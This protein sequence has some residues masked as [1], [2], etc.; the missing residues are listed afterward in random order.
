MNEPVHFSWRE[1]VNITGGQW[2][3]KPCCAEGGIV[4][5]CDDSRR[6]TPGM[7]FVAIPGELVDG[8]VYVTKA[9]AGGA[10]AVMVSRSPAADELEK[11]TVPCLLVEDSL[12][13]FQEL[14]RAHR[15]RF[16][17]LPLLGITGSCGKTSTKE[18]CAAVL[19]QHFGSQIVK[20]EGNTNNHFGVPRNLFR[21]SPE[22][23]MAVIEMGSNH[24][25]EIAGLA[26]LAEPNVSL[27]CNIGHAHLEF[28]HDLYGVATEKSNI[29]SHCADNGVA[30]FP[31]EAVGREILAKAAGTRRILTFGSSDKA[32]IQSRYLG[33]CGNGEFALELRWKST[34]E[35]RR[36][37]WKLGGLHQAMNA[38][39][40]AAAGTAFG[41]TP[42]EIVAGLINTVLPGKRME[43]V[44]KGGIT[45]ANDAYNAN[46]DSTAAAL[47]W[48]A[49]VCPK[50][51]GQVLVLG[52]MRELGE[53]SAA[54]HEEILSKALEQ[55]PS[56]HI[57][58]VGTMFAASAGKF[59]QANF[60]DVEALRPVL[61]TSLKKGDWVLLKGS[62]GVGLFS[63]L[64]E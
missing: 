39:A 33:Y 52:E 49:E 6:I 32:D 27:V 62:N 24:P 14:S 42:D 36:L 4:G 53:N 61:F 38:A 1:L 12:K 63:L 37:Q 9:V 16:P 3:V 2:L 20:T 64:T 43:L 7:L 15:R 45:W 28:F 26:R 46:P 48:F 55:F 34:G 40:A 56:A 54:A 57:F 17:E 41:L 29:L 10:G 59:N 13:A 22:T 25:G 30:I 50:G 35:V 5:V 31:E 11:I 51:A 23:K 44:E 8:H 19:A 21:I 58:T 47:G 60:P 18:M